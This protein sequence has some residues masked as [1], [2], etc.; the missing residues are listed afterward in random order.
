MHYEQFLNNFFF[1]LNSKSVSS[2]SFGSI[3]RNLLFP[4]RQTFDMYVNK[5]G[6]YYIVK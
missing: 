4:F 6:F 3:K 5:V 1:T 2:Q